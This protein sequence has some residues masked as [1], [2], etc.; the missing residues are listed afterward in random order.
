MSLNEQLFLE[1]AVASVLFCHRHR[2]I[3]NLLKGINF[4]I[5]RDAMFSYSHGARERFME[6]PIY[7]F[8]FFHFQQEGGPT[9]AHSLAVVGNSKRFREDVLEETER[10]CAEAVGSMTFSLLFR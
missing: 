5:M 9:N 6:R 4:E 2:K 3:D 1:Q 10:L 8:L 7:A